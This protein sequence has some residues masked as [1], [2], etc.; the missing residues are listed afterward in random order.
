MSTEKD[1]SIQPSSTKPKIF[2]KVRFEQPG[3]DELLYRTLEVEPEIIVQLVIREIKQKY[4][5]TDSRQVVFRLYKP[6]EEKENS[7]LID[8]RPESDIDGGMWLDNKNPLSNYIQP[9]GYLNTILV[10]KNCLRPLKVTDIDQTNVKTI[11]ILITGSLDHLMK[12]I[13]LR[14][15]ISND[16]DY[17]F[18]IHRDNKQVW[19][20]H[21][22]PL[23]KQIKSSDPRII[24][25]KR[26][27]STD[28]L[29]T[30]D[31]YGLQLLYLE[32]RQGVVSG[33]HPTTL[34]QALRFA[35]LQMQ[36]T[37]RNY[38]PLEHV[39]GFFN[40]PEFLPQQ[41][42]ETEMIEE[43]VYKRHRQLKDLSE[44][45]GKYQYVKLLKTFPTYG[46]H[47]ISVCEK[48]TNSGTYNHQLCVGV[49][50]ESLLCLHPDT[51]KIISKYSI[52]LVEEFESNEKKLQWKFGKE[53]RYF[54][55]GS[56]EA[57]NSIVD[58]VNRYLKM[59]NSKRH[60][61]FTHKLVLSPRDQGEKEKIPK[62]SSSVFSG[63]DNS[64]L[65]MLPEKQKQVRKHWSTPTMGLIE[66]ERDSTIGVKMSPPKL[67]AKIPFSVDERSA[68]SRTRKE[69]IPKP[70]VVNPIQKRRSISQDMRQTPAV[71]RERRSSSLPTT[72]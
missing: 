16:L 70:S 63:T 60:K 66:S 10:F 55:C 46:L 32:C 3:P 48:L 2:L 25:R 19:L 20:S 29:R 67:S 8:S 72:D 30:R 43:D 64:L 62:N 36:I 23:H 1:P 59:L 49:N 37:Y 12:E 71:D 22:I 41:W 68:V 45:Q 27:F 34:D 24:I 42:C 17:G 31:P 57:A 56:N 39:A 40:C 28:D 13:G 54:E 47:Y 26:Y 15:S 44:A 18:Q 35:A 61:T 21:D 14:F 4:G 11:P 50:S 69:N 33:F 9:D 6:P 38:D 51:K 53:F 5:Y 7:D 58:M 52:H 65:D